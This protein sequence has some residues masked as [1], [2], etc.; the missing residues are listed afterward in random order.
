[1]PAQALEPLLKTK[2]HI[3]QV[4]HATVERPQLITAINTGVLS[5]LTLVSAP[6]GFGK[7]TAL[8]EWVRQSPLP[9]AWVSLDEGDN[10]PSR[11]FLYLITALRNICGSVGVDALALLQSPQP[12]PPQSILATLLSDLEAIPEPF[13][14]VLDDFHTITDPQIQDVFHF[15][16]EHIPQAMHVIIAT[17]IDPPI[18]LARL[19]T[20]REMV[21]LRV[22]DLRFSLEEA[23]SFFNQIMELTLRPEDTAVLAGRTEGWI[24]GLQ[25]AA[26]ALQGLSMQSREDQ[27]G[28]IRAFSGSNRYIMDY[29]V[30][31]VLSRQ[32]EDLQQFLLSTAILDRLSGSLCDAVTQGK[33][34]QAKLEQLEKANLFLIPLDDDRHWYR[35]HHL[36]AELLRAQPHRSDPGLIPQLHLR[37]SRWFE[38]NGMV[39]EAVRHALAAGDWDRSAGL[40]EVNSW[41]AL[42]R[43]ELATFINWVDAL[44]KEVVESHPR[45][46]MYTAWFSILTGRINA[47]E[48]A[49]NQAE[50]GLESCA[51]AER[52]EIE[53][54]IA[55]IR[56]HAAMYRAD[57][58]AVLAH[59]QQA[60][61]LLPESNIAVR[62]IVNYMI[63]QAHVIQNDLV[64]ASR[65]IEEAAQLGQAVGNLQLAVAALS[66]LSRNQRMLGQLHL[67]LA[68]NQTVFQLTHSGDGRSI[69]LAAWA[70]SGMSEL[71]YEWNDLP[72]AERE[73]AEGIRL[74]GQY[75][76]ADAMARAPIAL[77]RVLQVQGRFSEAKEALQQAEEKAKAYHL[78]AWISPFLEEAR[79]RLW[80]SP[81]VW[82]VSAAEAWLDS[83]QR[84][85][86]TEQN[87]LYAGEADTLTQARVLVALNQFDEA[88]ERLEPLCVSAK[89]GG[90]MGRWVEIMILRAVAFGRSGDQERAL[91]AL[92]Q[93]LQFAQP[94][95]YL[96]TFL[97]EGEP[98]FQLLC[99]M[100]SHSKER[101]LSAYI[102]R[103]LTGFEGDRQRFQACTS[104]MALPDSQFNFGS[105]T[106]DLEFEAL[107]ARE[108]EIL[109]LIAAG[110]S[111][112][113]I[114]SLLYLAVSTV[115]RH[116]NHIFGKLGVRT[117]AQ[118][119]AKARDQRLV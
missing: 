107:T 35:Y 33:D 74:A 11:F 46:C 108:V 88:L 27:A 114:A 97:D 10:D 65:S 63:G 25:M 13:V 96:R 31:E 81:A 12:L 84:G 55:A 28:F 50:Q 118:A 53:G 9:V 60:L 43:G 26:L 3:P 19:R 7:T 94:E 76:L 115:K 42:I 44:P 101:P 93:A 99:V 29:L 111:N 116:V 49:L 117:R 104:D 21:E 67:A 89:A 17:R 102:H 73:A 15:L 83:R 37:A 71:H 30:E 68:T 70:Y 100:G 45:L 82:D 64:M 58:A 110:K 52:K 59:A 72:V 69:P 23:S 113:E 2:L 80:L 90:R 119:I 78:V 1:M 79:V 18:P 109:R 24:A 105:I 112:G 77:A 98:L 22:K 16:L 61:Y 8:V 75:A 41:Q 106:R 34:G 39:A 95:G 36:F 87:L 86:A 6:A 51:P 54:T 20:Q 92:E 38:E 91:I 57:A 62:S 40:I 48:P 85:T 4:R 103:L 56:S 14:L 5:A 66:N 32:P 47:V